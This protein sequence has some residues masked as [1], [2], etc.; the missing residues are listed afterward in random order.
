MCMLQRRGVYINKTLRASQERPVAAQPS[1]RAR[2]CISALFSGPSS[3]ARPCPSTYET[4]P[5]AHGTVAAPGHRRGRVHRALSCALCACFALL[6]AADT[7]DICTDAAGKLLTNL[8]EEEPTRYSALSCASAPL[9]TVCDIS[10]S[11]GACAALAEC[12]TLNTRIDATCT[13]DNEAN[14][15][16]T[17]FWT[18]PCATCDVT[19]LACLQ[20]CFDEPI[21]GV[22]PPAEPS[23]TSAP[24]PVPA[25]VPAPANETAAEDTPAPVPA[26]LTAAA[27]VDAIGA[28]GGLAG[29]P[30]LT[31]TGM[32]RQIVVERISAAH[33]ALR[34]AA[35][36]FVAAAAAAVMATFAA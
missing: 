15:C 28:A 30:L 23:N 32:P 4:M 13:P 12:R 2:C 18:L 16:C 10:G 17:T 26:A 31:P 3:A 1:E 19:A 21:L 25:P 22:L 36:V 35:P 24:A 11:A 8:A 9:T 33:A 34:G 6:A 20:F 29:D 5:P 27:P 7:P 14:A